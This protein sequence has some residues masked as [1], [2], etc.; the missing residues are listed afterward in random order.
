MAVVIKHVVPSELAGVLFTADPVTGHYTEYGGQLRA[1]PGR[2]GLSGEAN[3]ESFHL[4]RPKGQYEGPAALQPY[5]AEL[6]KV[7]SPT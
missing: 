7:A 4:S 6:Y 2:A 1:W 3:A 5:A